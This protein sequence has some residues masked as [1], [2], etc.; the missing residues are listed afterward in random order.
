VRP[1]ARTFGFLRDAPRLHAAG[2][3]LGASPANTLIYD[4][5]GVP[6]SP[7]R[8]PDEPAHHKLLDLLGD[9]A[10]LGAPLQAPGARRQGGS[11][12]APCPGAG[13]SSA[14]GWAG[15]CQMR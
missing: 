2:L 7:L 13:D 4:D 10:L 3:A 1:H 14:S 11:P 6:R 5:A 9:L 8:F 12:A 15:A